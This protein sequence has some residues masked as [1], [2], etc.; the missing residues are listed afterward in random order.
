V[1]PLISSRI[2][3]GGGS[4]V[5]ETKADIELQHETQ[6]ALDRSSGNHD[7]NIQASRKASERVLK[8][9]VGKPGQLRTGK[10]YF[11]NERDSYRAADDIHELNRSMDRDRHYKKKGS[12]NGPSRTTMHNVEKLQK[13]SEDITNR[14]DGRNGVT[15]KDA[16]DKY[17]REY[18]KAL[19]ESYYGY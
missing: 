3:S 16:E 12:Q 9:G 18:K 5:L 13:D 2:C 14:W 1:K 10:D 4:S 7:K 11:D 17:N 8:D 19:H 6:R 15:R